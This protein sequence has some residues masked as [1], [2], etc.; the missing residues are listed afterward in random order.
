MY[1]IL[2]IVMRELNLDL[3][4][5]LEWTAAYHKVVEERFMEGMERLPTFS[6]EVDRQ[7]REYVLG[8]A[9]W[10]RSN[11]CWNF[12]SGRYFGNKGLEI[13]KTRCVPLMPK[14]MKDPTMKTKDVEVTLVEL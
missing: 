13:Q 8:L 5:A 2:T 1:N 4:G 10:P 12:E 11:D 3:K 9:M 14:K 7:L 6:P